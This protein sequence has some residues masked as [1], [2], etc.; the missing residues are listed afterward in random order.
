[1]SADSQTDSLGEKLVLF[2]EKHHTTD[3]AI[4][5]ASHLS[6]EKIHGIKMG[7]Y[8]PNSEEEKLLLE[9]I[10]NYTEKQ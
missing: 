9:F 1:M 3:A 2:Q 5:L 7:K 8:S 10:N 4:S 6:V